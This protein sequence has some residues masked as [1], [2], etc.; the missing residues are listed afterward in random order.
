[1]RGIVFCPGIVVEDRMGGVAARMLRLLG[2]CFVV[3]L[4]KIGGRLVLMNRGLGVMLGRR[5]MVV[6]AVEPFLQDRR[7]VQRR[8]RQA[9]FNT[10]GLTRNLS[11]K[12]RPA[13]LIRVVHR[14]QRVTMRQQRLVGGVGMILTRAIV[15]RRFLMVMRSALVVGGSRGMALGVHDS[16]G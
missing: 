10:D 11:G 16:S 2:R 8:D 14:A 1:M 4:A 3:S 9:W 15:P 13:G 12:P 7:R 6:G 5:H